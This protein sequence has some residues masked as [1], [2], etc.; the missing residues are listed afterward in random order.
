MQIVIM[1][2]MALMVIENVL[3]R[4]QIIITAASLDQLDD[5]SKFDTYNNIC[6]TS[7]CGREILELISHLFL[8]I[9][10]FEVL[11]KGYFIFFC[12][13]YNFEL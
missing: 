1:L 8:A 10:I 11:F 6:D 5:V 4:K 3:I 7:F 12:L 13:K 9:Y 2:N